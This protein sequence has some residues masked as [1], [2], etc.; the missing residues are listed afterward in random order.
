MVL[1]SSSQLGFV[2]LGARSACAVSGIP[3]AW[4]WPRPLG[5]AGAGPRA[6]AL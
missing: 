3:L 2:S 1:K 5:V 4:F 6:S